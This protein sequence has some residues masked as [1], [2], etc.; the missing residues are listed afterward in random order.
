MSTSGSRI[1]QM[2]PVLT[3]RQMATARRFAGADA[4]KFEAGETALRLR[5]K[6]A[7]IWIVLEGSLGGLPP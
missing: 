5:R 4:H 6:A 7:P 2:F 3:A 1:E